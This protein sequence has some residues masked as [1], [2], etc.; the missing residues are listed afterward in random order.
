MKCRTV[1]KTL[2][3]V[4]VLVDSFRIRF[5]PMADKYVE[6]LFNNANTGYAEVNLPGCAMLCLNS[7]TVRE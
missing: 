2:T 6:L 1:T 4:A 7:V 5:N 3:I